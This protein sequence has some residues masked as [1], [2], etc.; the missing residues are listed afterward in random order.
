MKKYLL[1]FALLL[2][3]ATSCTVNKNNSKTTQ[4]TEIS[5]IK[6][7]DSSAKNAIDYKVNVLKVDS[8]HTYLRPINYQ[9]LRYKEYTFKTFTL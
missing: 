9:E 2:L 8:L 7:A 4:Q 1:L 3:F 6:I 5:E